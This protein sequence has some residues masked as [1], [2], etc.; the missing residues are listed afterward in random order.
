MSGLDQRDL[1]VLGHYARTGNRELYWNYLAQHPGSDGYGLLALGVVR[2]DNAPGQVANLYADIRARDGGRNMRESDWEGFGVDLI[3]QDL[4]L[5]R[6]QL[7]SDRPDLALN[8]PARDVQRAHDISFANARIDPNAWTPRVLLEAARNGRGEAE[9]E[10]IWS[11]MLDNDWRGS[12]RMLN[13]LNDIRRN[14]PVD[15]AAGYTARLTGVRAAV[16]AGAHPNTDPNTIGGPPLTYSYNQRDNSWSQISS[17][18]MMPHVSEVTNP[19]LLAE[20]NDAR[21]T[22][23]H[24]QDL[25]D[26]FHPADPNRNR[27]IMASP[28]VVADAGNPDR[29]GTTAVA[30]AAASRPELTPAQCAIHDQC[31]DGVQRLAA[32]YGPEAEANLSARLARLAGDQGFRQV[33]AVVTGGGNAFI[34]EGN[35]ADPANRNAHVGLREGLETPAQHSLQAMAAQ[36]AQPREEP[37]PQQEQQRTAARAMA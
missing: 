10:R 30:L 15:D 20:L 31:R 34:V 37:A 14:M 13:T 11:H 26:D 7:R 9:V 6:Q 24:R 27:P 5:R 16:A 23:L 25:R 2:N 17:G 12:E 21:T 8:L 35:P 36:G 19:R 33:D 22:R 1:D 28:W 29:P 32:G 4:E 18:G 3:R